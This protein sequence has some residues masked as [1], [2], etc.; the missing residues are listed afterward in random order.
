MPFRRGDGVVLKSTHAD[1][2]REIGHK[3][4]RLQ[5]E[6]E[7]EPWSWGSYYG[8]VH[9]IPRDKPMMVS[10]VHYE[11]GKFMLEFRVPEVESDSPVLFSASDFSPVTQDSQVAAAV[12]QG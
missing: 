3:G 10:R 5:Y 12:A 11:D 2:C 1:S 8:V 6:P 4:W 7:N 9:V